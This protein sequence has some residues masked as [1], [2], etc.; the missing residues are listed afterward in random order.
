M[1]I[2]QVAILIDAFGSGGVQL[3][4]IALC[5]NNPCRE[6]DPQLEAKRAPTQVDEGHQPSA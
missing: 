2:I 3:I 5:L 1:N 4:Q 6:E